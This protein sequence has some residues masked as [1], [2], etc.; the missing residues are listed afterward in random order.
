[1]ATERPVARVEVGY[2]TSAWSRVV[3]YVPTAVLFTTLWIVL[4][5][6]PGVMGVGEVSTSAINWDAFWAFAYAANIDGFLWAFGLLMVLV[7]SCGNAVAWSVDPK[8]S[9]ACRILWGA[10]LAFS[11]LTIVAA[12]V[13]RWG[14]HVWAFNNGLL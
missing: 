1:M 11:L 14:S 6:R 5:W 8:T 9:L 7:S 13:I 2:A 4:I 12:G 10:I 3:T